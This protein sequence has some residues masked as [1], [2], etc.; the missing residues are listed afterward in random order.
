M[1]WVTVKGRMNCDRCGRFAYAAD[2][3]EE[4]WAV[5]CKRHLPGT[6]KDRANLSNLPEGKRCKDCKHFAGGWL[7]CSLNSK[8]RS[9]NAS[10]VCDWYP[11]RFEPKEEEHHV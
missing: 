4:C 3:D 11:S 1:S 9:Q 5:R 2:I 6:D 8:V 10:K 7:Y